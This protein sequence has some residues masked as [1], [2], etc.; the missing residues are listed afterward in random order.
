V[1]L[2]LAC[3][4]I[5]HAQPQEAKAMEGRRRGWMDFLVVVLLFVV[6]ADASPTSSRELKLSLPRPKAA[7]G[8]DWSGTHCFA[9]LIPTFFRSFSFSFVLFDFL[10][11]S[12]SFFL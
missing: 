4:I 11:I 1:A 7:Q 10:L 12:F 6:W 9:F 5:N 3:A 8:C 2:V